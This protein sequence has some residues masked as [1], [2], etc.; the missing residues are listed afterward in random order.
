MT[1]LTSNHSKPL[2]SA[3]VNG[4]IGNAQH[5]PNKTDYIYLQTWLI[6]AVFCAFT[7]WVAFDNQIFHIMVDTD[8]SYLSLA[9]IIV[10]LAASAHAAWHISATATRIKAANLYLDG[11]QDEGFEHSDIP[12]SARTSVNLDDDGPTFIGNFLRDVGESQAHSHRRKQ[13]RPDNHILEIYADQL[14]SPV[15]IGWFIVDLL[16]RLGLLGTIVGFILILRTLVSGPLPSAD[17]IQTLLISMSG[18]MGTALFTTLAGLTT[19]TLLG[20]Q[21]M[22]LGR[23]VETLIASLIRINE[24]TEAT[25]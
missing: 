15:E 4:H 14:R 10:F 9:T 3:V 20:L 22:V 12:P 11:S 7:A 5:P 6:I 2:E 13:D 8:K 25:Q 16:I 24:R 23:S 17:Q 18:G 1:E 21:Y 19:A